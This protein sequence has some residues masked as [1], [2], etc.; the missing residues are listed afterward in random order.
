MS[1]NPVKKATLDKQVE[2]VFV[3]KKINSLYKILFY[4]FFFILLYHII[5]KKLIIIFIILIY[6]ECEDKCLSCKYR[7]SYCTEC[8]DAD[9]ELP[10]C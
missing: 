9:L 4:T 8:S 6:L 2:N 10:H 1:L 7:A 3:I 5:T